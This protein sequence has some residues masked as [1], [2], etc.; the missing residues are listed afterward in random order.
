MSN[1]SHET[2]LCEDCGCPVRQDKYG[3]LFYR[4]CP[5]CQRAFDVVMVRK[6]RRQ[7]RQEKRSKWRKAFDRTIPRLFHPAHIRRLNH[8]LRDMLLSKPFQQGTL[9]WGPVGVG[10][11]FAAS[12]LARLYITQGRWV[13]RITFRDLL[14]S[15]RAT[16]GRGVTEREVYEP[17]LGAST[18]IIEDVAASKS[19]DFSADVMLHILDSRMERCKPTVITSNLSPENLSKAFG[20][21]VGSRLKTFLIVRL[22]GRDQREAIA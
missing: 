7:D 2:K 1:I 13:Q 15:L 18:L 4:R 17:L 11:T 3:N 20:Q 21:R 9:I 10:K 14:L 6:Q 22:G 12:A 19:T 8:Q 16:Y 5:D